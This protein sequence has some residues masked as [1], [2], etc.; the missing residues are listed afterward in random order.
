MCSKTLAQGEVAW[1]DSEKKQVI[2][3]IFKPVSDIETQ[4][5]MKETNPPSTLINQ[6]RRTIDSGVAGKSAMEEYQRRHTKRE[7]AI[8]AKWGRLAGVVKFFS[9]DP[10]ST[11]AWRI[12]SMGEQ[13]LAESLSSGL[14]DSEYVLHDRRA[15]RTEGN[16]DHLVIARTGLWV[17]DAKNYVGKVELRYVGGFFTTDHR[18]YVGGRDRSKLVDGLDWQ[19]EAV[20]KIVGELSVSITPALC[21]TDSEWGWF[22][23]PFFLKGVFVSAP[24]ALVRQI[25]HEPILSEYDCYRIALLLSEKM[26]AK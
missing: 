24:G 21:F 13:K 18:L 15:P 5:V 17:I 2:C 12:G 11:E 25:V 22:A 26:P 19:V 23:K 10:H 16:I 3:T 8:D 1:W 14:A 6:P 7:A 20:R 4:S 9:D